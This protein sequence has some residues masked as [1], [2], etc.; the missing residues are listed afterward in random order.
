MRMRKY[1]NFKV[2]IFFTII[3]KIKKKTERRVVVIG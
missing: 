1:F 2:K 3:R